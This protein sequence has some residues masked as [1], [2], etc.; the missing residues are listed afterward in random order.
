MD[1]SSTLLSALGAVYDAFSGYLRP[2]RLDASPTRDPAKMLST[3]SSAPLRALKGEQIGPYSGWALT[4]VGSV[5]DYKH[6]LPRILEQ[7][8]R[9][10]EWMGTQPPVIAS[11][12]K[13][14][15]WRTWPQSEQLAVTA[16]F[17]AALR[18]SIHGHPDEGS[19]AAEWLCGVASLGEDLEIVLQEWLN[20]ASGNALLQIAKLA[21]ELSSLGSLDP[22]DQIFWAD[23]EPEVRTNIVAWLLS[24]PVDAAFA[25]GAGIEPNDTWRIEQGRRA[26]AEYRGTS[27]Q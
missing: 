13:M 17:R 22:G 23:I 5:T 27:Q 10:P 4:T 19:D 16:L 21:T 8:V 25:N 6:F 15:E 18:D 2:A 20:E 11:R 12:L 1:P 26:I 7:A 3:L 14:A 9:A 24:A